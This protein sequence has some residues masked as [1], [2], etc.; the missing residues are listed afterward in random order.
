MSSSDS[1]MSK[2]S[3]N[4]RSEI[5]T[6][7]IEISSHMPIVSKA[8]YQTTV[9]TK[10]PVYLLMTVLGLLQSFTVLSLVHVVS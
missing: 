9:H 8:M 1:K 3:T 4:D 6:Y 7:T 10:Y 5:C 2:V